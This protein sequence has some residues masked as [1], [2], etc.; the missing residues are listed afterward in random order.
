[1]SY[2]FHKISLKRGK[3]YVK[4]PQWVINKRTTIN[5]KNIENKCFQ[6]SITI[7]LNHQN[8]EN[9]PERASNIE[10]FINQYNWKDIYFPAGIKDWKK[11]ERNNKTI[12][13]NILSIPHNTK[14]NKSCI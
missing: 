14:K 13:L 3:S 1:M 2:T 10:P 4:S 9:H 7:A 5:P 11:S 12:A 6:Y 8:I